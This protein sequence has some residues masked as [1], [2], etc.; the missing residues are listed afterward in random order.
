MIYQ[1]Y[2]FECYNLIYTLAPV[3]IL[4]IKWPTLSKLFGNRNFAVSALFIKNL[5]ETKDITIH[6]QSG[7]L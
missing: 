7:L 5:G 1:I 2:T 3:G 4:L 6:Y